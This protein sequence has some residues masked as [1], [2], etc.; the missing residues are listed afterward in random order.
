MALEEEVQQL[1]SRLTIMRDEQRSALEAIL[2]ELNDL[3]ERVRAQ[4]EA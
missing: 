4:L 2:Q 3:T 1:R